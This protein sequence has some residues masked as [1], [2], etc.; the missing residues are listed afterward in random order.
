LKLLSSPDIAKRFHDLLNEVK[1]NKEQYPVLISVFILTLLN[2]NP[3]LD[4]LVDLWGP[5]ILNSTGF[6]RSPAIKQFVDFNRSQVVLRSSIVA[7]YL[8]KNFADASLITSVLTDLTKCADKNASF[9]RTHKSLFGALLRFGN[10]QMVLP[11]EG[12]GAAVIRYYESIKNLRGCQNNPLFWLQYA[13]ACLVINALDRAERY[14][15]TAY[16][17]ADAQNWDTFQIDNHFARFLLVNAIE[18]LN[19][20]DAMANFRKARQI[21]NRQVKEEVLHHPYRVATEYQN[22]LDKF[23]VGLSTSQLSDINQ[24]ADNVLNHINSLDIDRRRHRYVR[25]CETAMKYVITRINEI[26]LTKTN[27]ES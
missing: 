4:L 5:D 27:P 23:G 21:I 15:K 22:F 13:I 2:Q 10:V 8:L 25:D 11:I 20:N 18:N 3:S 14:F 12:R 19:S 26:L 7:E 16:S 17:L 6:R 9:S 24:G 1:G